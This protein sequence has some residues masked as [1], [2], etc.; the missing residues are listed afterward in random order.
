[1]SQPIY[2]VTGAHGFIGAWVVK[3]LLSAGQNVVIFDKSADPHRLRLI[4]NE[5]EIARPVVIEGDITDGAVVSEIVEKQQVTHIIHLAGL[6]VPTCR[7]N[8]RLGAMVNVIGTLNV[9]EAA[10]NSGGR[11]KRVAYASSAA[12]FGKSDDAVAEG[13]A[14][15]M[16]THYGA[17]KRCNE[18]NA[19][20]YYLDNG[21]SSVGLRPLTVYGPGRDTGMTSD[22]TKAMKAAVV[23]RPFHIRFGGK[24]DFL[25]VADCADVFIRAA[26]STLEGAHVFNSHGETIDV[27]AVV[28]EIEAAIPAAKGTITFDP[29]PLALPPQLDDSAVVEA[30]G[31]IPHTSLAQGTRETIERFM[32]LHREGRLDTSDLDG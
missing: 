11:V 1:M 32:L 4:M 31:D 22:P 5:D 21:I 27:S 7:A 10:K 15:G 24:T 14:G 26:E 16:N 12:V 29:T 30:L 9:F 20:V 28:T 19:R 2:L 13:A 8:P 3:R 23:G 25:Y 17:F 18:D 6:Q